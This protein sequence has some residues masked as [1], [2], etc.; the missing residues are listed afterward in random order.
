[1]ATL[2]I[3]EQELTS[4][5]SAYPKDRR[6]ALAA[7][8]DMQRRFNY[9]PREGLTELAGYFGCPVASLYSMATF[10]KGL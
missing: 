10:Y 6:Y 2:S 8:Q 4:L 9:V 7:M 1:M 5:F 3:S